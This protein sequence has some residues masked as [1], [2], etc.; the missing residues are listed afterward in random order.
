MAFSSLDSG[1]TGPL[2]ATERMRAVFSDRARLAAMLRTEAALARA[3]AG[4]G[5]APQ[6]LATAIEAI[7]PAALDIA[8]L[9][10]TGL[11]ARLR[12]HRKIAHVV[13]DRPL[14]IEMPRRADRTMREADA[15][16]RALGFEREL[17]IGHVRPRAVSVAAVVLVITAAITATFGP[18][19]ASAL[20]GASE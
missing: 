14:V 2:F 19:R 7:D 10:M 1:L 18:K 20:P 16:H 4:L 13:L 12:D 3:Q 9:A 6:N 17:T 8:G 15:D 5:L 11:V